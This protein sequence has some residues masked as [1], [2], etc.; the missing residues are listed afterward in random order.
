MPSARRFTITEEMSGASSLPPAS[1]SISD[2]LITAWYGDMPP[3]FA[4][5]APAPMASALAS[6]WSTIFWRIWV[7]VSLAPMA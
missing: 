3:L 6:N 5:E 7:S 1:A 4:P 2:A